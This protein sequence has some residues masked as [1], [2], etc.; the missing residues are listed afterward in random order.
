MD[1]GMNG[2]LLPLSLDMFTYINDVL[3]Y[4]SARI[5]IQ[6]IRQGTSILS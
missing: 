1:S 5:F 4:G 2:A 3:I 6:C